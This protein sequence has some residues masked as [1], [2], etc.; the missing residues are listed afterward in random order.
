MY[1]FTGV[2]EAPRYEV[3]SNFRFYETTLLF[4]TPLEIDKNRNVLLDLSNKSAG[5]L[6]TSQEANQ[7]K[8]EVN[9]DIN[10]LK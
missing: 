7:Q 4:L 8:K 10:I 1:A 5:E 6:K 2:L 9:F 3:L